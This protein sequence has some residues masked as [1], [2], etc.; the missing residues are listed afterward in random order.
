MK[1][2]CLFVIGVFALFGFMF[3]VN[4]ESTLT[5]SC[6]NNKLKVGQTTNCVVYLTADI[7]VT[8][9]KITMDPS[10]HL[11][12]T[13]VTANS[14]AG[15]TKDS[16]GTNEAA[17]QFAFNSTAATGVTGRTPLFS[18]N[19]TLNEKAKKLSNG[20]IC[21]Q[22]CFSSAILNNSTQIPI[23]KG[24]GTCFGPAVVNDSP[25]TPDNPETGAFMNYVIIAG[26]G[27][28][29]VAGVVIARRSSKFFRI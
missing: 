4:A 24:T 18:F 15:W 14:A 3:S 7:A 25:T 26:V 28:L 19:L 5:M 29:A 13:A 21:G 1:K 11:D 22:L 9:I 2:T 6:E 17:Y 8:N 20:D 27:V 12:L 10:E 23:G 16:T